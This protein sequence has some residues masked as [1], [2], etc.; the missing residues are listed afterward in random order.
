L[1]NLFG[2][3][4]SLSF[5]LLN[6]LLLSL[7]D[8]ILMKLELEGELTGLVSFLDLSNNTRVGDLFIV[9]NKLGLLKSEIVVLSLLGISEFLVDLILS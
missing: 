1:L 6:N 3:H 4:T 7:V 5:S 8:F 2:G 9:S